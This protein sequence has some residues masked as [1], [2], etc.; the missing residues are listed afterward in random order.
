MNVIDWLEQVKKLDELI[1]AKIA[2]RNQVWTMITSMTVKPQ[3]DMPHAKGG[4]SDPV[5][6]GVVKLQ[7]LSE[8]IDKLVDQ[9][10]DHKRQVIAMLEKLSPNEYGAL[11]RHYI[12]H[13]TW[14]NVAEDMGKSIMQI[15][16][17]RKKG[18]K[19]LTNAIEC[20]T[21]HSV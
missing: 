3:D 10:V 14:E 17:Y 5:G 4:I 9:Y 15:F 21:A 12:Q 1:N 16:R 2:E 18:L 11:H 19:N 6:N 20:Y 8:E 7:M 13:M